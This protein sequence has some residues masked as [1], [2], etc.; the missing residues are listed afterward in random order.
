MLRN[1]LLIATKVLMRRKFF[2][3]ISL[4]GISFTLVVLMVATAMLDNIFGSHAPEIKTD[5]TLGVYFMRMHNDEGF[6]MNGPPGYKFLNTYVRTLPGA[7]KISIHSVMQGVDIYKN[8][9][10]LPLYLK[11][12]DGEFWNIMEFEFIEGRPLTSDDEKNANA[13]AVINQ[14]TSRQLFGEGSA[15]GKS[16]DVGGRNYQVV[17]VVNNVSILRFTCFS[18]VWVPISTQPS[19]IYKDKFMD[20]FMASILAKSPDD[21]PLIKSDFAAML[22]KV[23]LPD[24]NLNKLQVNADT[25]FETISRQLLSGSDQDNR[26]GM[27]ITIIICIMILFMILPTINLVNIN[28]SRIIERS[29]EIGV[30]KAFGASSNILVGQFI[31]ENLLLTLVGGIVGFMLSYFVLQYINQQA[32]IRYADLQLNVRIFGYG[33]LTIVFFGLLSGVYPAWKMSKLNPVDALKGGSK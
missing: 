17:G 14:A 4:F 30:R 6:N 29:S 24:K 19:S 26:S 33:L 2:T 9:E 12:T 13:V 31:V 11:Y 23:E 22:T 7:E 5:R 27:M 32:L 18:D 28:I 25:F 15:L 10:A 8:G 20:N 1:Y 16:I 3:F 21:L